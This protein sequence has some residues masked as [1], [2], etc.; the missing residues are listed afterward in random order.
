LNTK[1]NLNSSNYCYHHSVY[2]LLYYYIKVSRLSTANACRKHGKHV[3]FRGRH[4]VFRMQNVY[5]II[6]GGARAES[7][8]A[9]RD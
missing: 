2:T 7:W 6:L 4:G 5:G 1:F 8:S 9:S 3:I